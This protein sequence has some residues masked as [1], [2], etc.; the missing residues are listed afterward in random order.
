M[1][2]DFRENRDDGDDPLKIK[3]IGKNLNKI[4]LL[5]NVYS[6]VDLSVIIVG[7]HGSSILLNSQPTF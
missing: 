7:A 4:N 1:S 5:V 2:Q 3:R 6:G